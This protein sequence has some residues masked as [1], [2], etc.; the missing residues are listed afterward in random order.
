MASGS[1]PTFAFEQALDNGLTAKEL[2]PPG[3]PVRWLVLQARTTAADPQPMRVMVAIQF[4][5]GQKLYYPTPVVFQELLQ[6][7]TCEP[8]N[9]GLLVTVAPQAGLILSATGGSH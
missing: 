6:E 9:T 5:N 7:G 1:V 8:H 2:I 4:G 3:T